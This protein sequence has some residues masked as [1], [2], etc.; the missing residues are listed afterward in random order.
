[1]KTNVMKSSSVWM[2]FITFFTLIL[3]YSLEF[4]LQLEPCPLCL[5]QR[6]CTISLGFLCLGNFTAPVWS[7]KRWYQFTQLGFMILGFILAS[8]QL[9][10][11]LLGPHDNSICMPGFEAILNYFSWDIII[12]MLFWGSNDCATVAWRLMGMPLSAWS[13]GYFFLMFILWIWQLRQMSSAKL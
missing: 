3:S 1:M 13:M 7:Q 5:M 12:K 9:W 8:R 11:Q 4:V 2:V 6:F 10:L